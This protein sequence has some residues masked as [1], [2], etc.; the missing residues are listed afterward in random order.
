MSDDEIS[1]LLTPGQR[2]Y[3]R[4]ESDIETGSANERAMRNRIRNRLRQSVADLGLINKHLETRDLEQTFDLIDLLK[5]SPQLTLLLDIDSRIKGNYSSADS[6]A[7]PSEDEIDGFETLY[8]SALRGLYIKRGYEV[9]KITV[10]IEVELGDD[11]DE[12]A[13]RHLSELSDREIIQLH[14]ANKI[15]S[16][17]F[18]DAL[19]LDADELDLEPNEEEPS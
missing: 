3:L 11:I 18:F 6:E 14:E 17:Q 8:S 16:R 12:I 7:L 2:D 1:A 15:S 13:K 5:L 4:G 9:E 10:D 19:G